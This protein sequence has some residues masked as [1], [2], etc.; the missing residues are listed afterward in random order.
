[1][2]PKSHLSYIFNTFSRSATLSGVIFLP[3]QY[4]RLGASKAGYNYRLIYVCSTTGKRITS[5]LTPARGRLVTSA[6]ARYWVT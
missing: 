6:A 2:S 3:S 1:M 5:S 4:S